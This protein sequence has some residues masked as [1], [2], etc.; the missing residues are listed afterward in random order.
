MDMASNGTVTNI[1]L[2]YGRAMGQPWAIVNP[3][4]AIGNFG[5]AP[6]LMPPI[7]RT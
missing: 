3:Q 5:I 4:S 1:G 2:F 7:T 6:I